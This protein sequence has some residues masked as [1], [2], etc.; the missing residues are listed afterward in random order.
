MI[1]VSNIYSSNLKSHYAIADIIT[2]LDLD[3][4]GEKT[5]T[6]DSQGVCLISDINTAANN[7]DLDMEDS[8]NYLDQKVINNS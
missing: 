2:S 8:G 3:P 4:S 1:Q 6:I 5:V 7:F